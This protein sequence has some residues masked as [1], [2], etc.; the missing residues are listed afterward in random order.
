MP[1][2]EE[3]L[4]AARGQAEP[5]RQ[6]ADARPLGSPEAPTQSPGAAPEQTQPAALPPPEDGPRL[7]RQAALRQ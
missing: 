6:P 5:L 1:P 2:L 4:V 7:A 3:L